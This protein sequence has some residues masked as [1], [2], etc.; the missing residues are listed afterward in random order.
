[1]Q[2]RILLMNVG[3]NYLKCSGSIVTACMFSLMFCDE[4][5]NALCAEWQGS[6][7]TSGSSLLWRIQCYMKGSVIV[8]KI[9]GFVC[10]LFVVDTLWHALSCTEQGPIGD[11]TKLVCH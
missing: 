7:C 3:T 2:A 1:M 11:A 5:G 6:R 10:K 8:Q 9:D 4:R